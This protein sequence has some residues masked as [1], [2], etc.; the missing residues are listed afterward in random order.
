MSP[1]TSILLLCALFCVSFVSATTSLDTILQRL[2]ALEQ[3]NQKLK[4]T[5]DQH[6]QLLAPSDDANHKYAFDV[7]LCK[8]CYFL[9]CNIP[10]EA[11][12]FH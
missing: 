1:L 7:S 5:I 11:S 12:A 8:L 6:N 2:N 3:E 9:L 4:S 10:T